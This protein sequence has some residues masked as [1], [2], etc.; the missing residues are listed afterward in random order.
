VSD[1]QGQHQWEV[2]GTLPG[3]GPDADQEVQDTISHGQTGPGSKSEGEPL[4]KEWLT[5][6]QYNEITKNATYFLTH[7]CPSCGE[8]YVTWRHGGNNSNSFTFNMFFRNPYG[9]ITPPATHLFDPGYGPRKGNW[10]PDR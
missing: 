4:A 5:T 10:F 3:G 2:E 9:S 1:P 6:D 8:N 7:T